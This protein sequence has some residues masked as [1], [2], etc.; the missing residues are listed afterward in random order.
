MLTIKHLVKPFLGR[1]FLLVTFLMAGFL[2][3]EDKGKLSAASI[4]QRMAMRYAALQSYQDEGVVLTYE[5]YNPRPDEIR[6]K[7]WFVRPGAF[8]FEW[9]VQRADPSHKGIKDY[10]VIWSEGKK[11]YIYCGVFGIDY[12]GKGA[13]ERCTSAGIQD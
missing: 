3:S 5:S 9:T 8:R 6:F 2:Y 1:P 11:A 12:S 13:I 7:T 4:V 10:W